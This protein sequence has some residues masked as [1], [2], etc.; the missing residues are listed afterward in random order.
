M[1]QVSLTLPI[2]QHNGTSNLPVIQ[3]IKTT[4]AQKYGGYSSSPVS[5][6]WIDEKSGVLYE[7]ESILVWTFVDGFDEVEAIKQYA[8]IW[9]HDLQQIELLV[10]VSQADVLFIAGTREQAA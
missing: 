5:G 4:L 1:L 8:S 9:A 7:D 3:H 2:K 10:T 6:G